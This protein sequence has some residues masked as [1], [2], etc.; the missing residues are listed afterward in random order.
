MKYHS[1]VLFALASVHSLSYGTC[2]GLQNNCEF[3]IVVLLLLLS[4]DRN[5]TAI[6]NN[7]ESRGGRLT[8]LLLLYHHFGVKLKLLDEIY[9]ERAERFDL[10]RKHNTNGWDDLINVHSSTAS[11]TLAIAFS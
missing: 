3:R 1:S 10:W 7:H 2:Y 9:D 8:D 11:I 5:I 6:T 4:D